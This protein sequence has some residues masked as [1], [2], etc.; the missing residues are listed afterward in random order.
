MAISA[1]VAG[2]G[3]EIAALLGFSG[4]SELLSLVLKTIKVGKTS[5]GVACLE[6]NKIIAKPKTR[7]N[8]I[9]K[10]NKNQRLACDIEILS[11]SITKFD[12]TEL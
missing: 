7:H 5:G 9:K 4:F 6:R 2:I 10:M 12:Y 3:L 11:F 1:S 8:K